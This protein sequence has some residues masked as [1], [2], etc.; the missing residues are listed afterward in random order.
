[1]GEGRERRLGGNRFF[2]LW[3]HPP[4]PDVVCADS[5]AGDW[6]VTGDFKNMSIV[7]TIDK[8]YPPKWGHPCPLNSAQPL[9]NQHSMSL[10][11]T[12]LGR[13]G[14]KQLTGLQRSSWRCITTGTSA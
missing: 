11:Q 1:M 7:A 4:D 2:L 13:H 3:R 6:E 12:M 8:L 14:V 9:L 5:A 10:P